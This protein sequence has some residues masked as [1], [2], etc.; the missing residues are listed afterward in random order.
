MLDI[1]NENNKCICCK[2][3]EESSDNVH[4]S[5][6]SSSKNFISSMLC[7]F[8]SIKLTKELLHHLRLY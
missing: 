7:A 1:L 6:Q 2:I 3:T 5:Q 4:K 8:F